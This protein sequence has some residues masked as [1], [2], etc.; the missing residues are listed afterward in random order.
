[1]KSPELAQIASMCG[2]G[3]PRDLGAVPQGI[4]MEMGDLSDVMA[5]SPPKA[6]VSS[7]KIDLSGDQ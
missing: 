2:L 6:A 5:Q 3:A 1:M 7:R 4:V